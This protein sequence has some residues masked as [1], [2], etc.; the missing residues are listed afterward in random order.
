[1]RLDCG[2]PLIRINS[3]SLLWVINRFAFTNPVVTS[4]YLVQ[5]KYR[6]SLV[7]NTTPQGLGN[8]PKAPTSSCVGFDSDNGAIKPV[9]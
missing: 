1:M 6:W 2:L 3:S 5:H 7:V 8:K 4:V 9:D